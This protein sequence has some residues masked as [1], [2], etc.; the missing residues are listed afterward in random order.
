MK[1]WKIL[2]Y[3][4]DERPP[5]RLS[6]ERTCL[7]D[8][9]NLLAMKET[10]W[11]KYQFLPKFP[12]FAHNFGAERRIYWPKYPLSAKN[13]PISRSYLYWVFLGFGWNYPHCKLSF[14]FG[15]ILFRPISILGV[16]SCLAFLQLSLLGFIRPSKTSTH[17]PRELYFNSF[18]LT[19][20]KEMQTKTSWKTTYRDWE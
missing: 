16:L 10:Y 13:E 17:R 9:R 11:L 7:W 15:P 6:A 12:F 18:S 5:F 19:K 1:S 8:P 3:R 14:R 20:M 4:L 2:G